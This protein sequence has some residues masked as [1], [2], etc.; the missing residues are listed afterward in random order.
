MGVYMSIP[1]V[2]ESVELQSFAVG[3]NS[4][5]FH[6]MMAVDD[7]ASWLWRVAANGEKVTLIV[8]T[9][10]AQILAL[11]DVYVTNASINDAGMTATLE[12]QEVRFF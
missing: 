5:T 7:T 10:P 4:K 2:V 9:L 8:M 12:A 3:D 1:D 6:I 11:D